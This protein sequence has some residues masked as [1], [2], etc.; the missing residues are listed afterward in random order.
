M[1]VVAPDEP[2]VIESEINQQCCDELP[3]LSGLHAVPLLSAALFLVG[4]HDAIEV[5]SH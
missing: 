1:P 5:F 2:E 4:I 3:A